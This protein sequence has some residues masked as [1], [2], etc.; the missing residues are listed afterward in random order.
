MGR[1]QLGFPRFRVVMWR[2]TSIA[3]GPDHT[4]PCLSVRQNP[5]PVSGRCDAT[6]AYRSWR[7]NT[8]GTTC[9]GITRCIRVGNYRHDFFGGT[10]AAIVSLIRDHIYTCT[11]GRSSSHIPV[12]AKLTDG[13][14]NVS[15][16]A[17]RHFDLRNCGSN[18]CLRVGVFRRFTLWYSLNTYICHVLS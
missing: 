14:G 10:I 18:F 1:P 13:T 12:Y 11:A 2:A 16:S 6:C 17:Y 4:P 8:G 9:G 5:R 3:I 15:K 7:R